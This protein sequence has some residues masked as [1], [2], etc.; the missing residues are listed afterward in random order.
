MQAAQVHMCCRF[1]GA[2]F[3]GAFEIRDEPFHWN[4]FGF[5]THVDARQV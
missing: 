5:D 1:V 3:Q 4:R 2:P